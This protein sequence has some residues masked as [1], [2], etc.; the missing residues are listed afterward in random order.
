[1][2]DLILVK[3][4]IF[5]QSKC[6]FWQNDSSE[7]FM[8]REQI[9]VALEYSNPMIAIYKI[10]E[11]HKDRFKKLSLTKLVNGHDTYFYSTKGV[12][13]IY[14]WSRQPKADAFMD[15]VWDV[16][17][18]IRTGKLTITPKSKS[19]ELEAEAKL[20][21]A[22]TRQVKTLLGT[23]KA[24]KSVASKDTIEKLACAAVEVLTGK[25]ILNSIED[26]LKLRDLINY[27]FNVM[28][29]EWGILSKALVKNMLSDYQLEYESGRMMPQVYK[30]FSEE[31][32]R[33]LN[34]L[35]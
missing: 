24:L 20:I 3:S 28:E 21:N 22:K 31:L 29:Q 10:H 33:R 1:M 17:E 12:Y 25:P 5:G 11:R 4:E 34:I 6:D 30:A 2:D 18:G 27:K 7:I 16:I 14:R 23:I 9:G 35:N 8:T 26:E 15:W 13:E 32:H 19:R